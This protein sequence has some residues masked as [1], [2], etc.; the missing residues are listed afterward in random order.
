[1]PNTEP[2]SAS[3]LCVFAV[4]LA[5]AL[6]GCGG[7]S[8]AKPTV[9]VAI[10]TPGAG[11]VA[12]GGGAV[13]VTSGNGTVSRIDPDTNKV[14]A[15]VD[16]GDENIEIAAISDTDVWISAPDADVVQRISVVKNSISAR[17]ALARGSS[18]KGGAIAAGSLWVALEHA[19]AVARIDPVKNVVLAKIAIGSVGSDGPLAVAESGGDVWVSVPADELSSALT[20]IPIVLWRR[21]R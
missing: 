6:S 13:W 18:P 2:T 8:T 16:V 21:F 9:D 15:T 7:S 10:P 12:T 19:G 5:D 3:G 14:V 11:Q 1:M 17:I 4:V 20:L